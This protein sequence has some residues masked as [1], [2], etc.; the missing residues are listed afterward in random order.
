MSLLGFLFPYGC[1]VN[2]DLVS[3][4]IIILLIGYNGIDV[5]II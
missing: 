5:T 4:V 1:L 3:F 2:T